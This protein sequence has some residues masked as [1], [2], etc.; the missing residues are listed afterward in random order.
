M[1]FLVGGLIVAYLGLMFI[2][3]GISNIR[4]NQAFDREGVPVNAVI[5]RTEMRSTRPT[6]PGSIQWSGSSDRMAV[7]YYRYKTRDGRQHEGSTNQLDRASVVSVGDTIKV[8][9]LPSDPDNSRVKPSYGFSTL[10]GLLGLVMLPSG[11]A[12]MVKGGK[13]LFRKSQQPV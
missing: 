12:M 11:I 13:A 10:L 7:V 4:L 1:L 6:K 2:A 8:S 3:G 9:Y 5:F